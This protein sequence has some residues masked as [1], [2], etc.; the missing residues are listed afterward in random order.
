MNCDHS[1]LEA[2]S[3]MVTPV[4]AFGPLLASTCSADPLWHP[5]KARECPQVQCCSLPPTRVLSRRATRSLALP[6]RLETSPSHVRA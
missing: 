2:R 6:P 3:V 5:F 4:P 1:G